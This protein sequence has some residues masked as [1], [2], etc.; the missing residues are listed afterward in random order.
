[1]KL[2]VKDVEAIAKARVTRAE[3]NKFNYWMIGGFVGII[4]GTFLMRYS[5][6]I[7]WIVVIIGFVGFLWYLYQVSKKQDSAKRK[8]VAEWRSE[9]K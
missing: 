6:V 5:N 2:D 3:G 1:M 7:G 8:L 9:Q 4:I